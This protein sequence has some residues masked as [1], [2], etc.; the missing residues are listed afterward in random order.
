MRLKPM[1][2]YSPRE[3]KVRVARLIWE[4]GNVGDGKGYSA[5]L[6]LA[7]MPR[8]FRIERSPLRLRVVMLGVS[9]HY[10]RTYGGRFA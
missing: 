8:L 3:R 9:L 10:A 5:F 4:R 2:T 1:F 7:L 6:S